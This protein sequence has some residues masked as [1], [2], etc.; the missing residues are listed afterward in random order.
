M[1][2]ATRPARRYAA[3][4]AD[5][6]QSAADRA[7]SNPASLG[8]G[9]DM[10]G[11]GGGQPASE[12]Y[13]LE[14]LTRAYS[15]AILEDGRAVLPYGP[16]GGLPALRQIVAER[17]GMRG[18]QIGPENVLILTGSIQGL[19]LV[20]RITLDHGD[21]I[22]TEAPTFMGALAA[23]EHQQPNYL[24][25]PVDEHGMVVEAL[26]DALRSG[27]ANRHPKFVYLMPTFQNPSG[28]SLT[29]HRRQRLLEI[30][31]E[32]DLLIVEDDPYGEFWFD[33]AMG[34]MPP[35]KSLPG[36]E[37]RVIYLGTFSKILAPG[38][39]L[40]YAVAAPA[41]IELLSRAK[42]GI[43][44]HSDTLLQQAVVHLIRDPE[45]DFEAHVVEGRQLYKARR[46]AMLDS[47]EG[48]FSTETRWTRPGGGFFLWIDLPHGVSG[49]AVTAAAQ[50][51]G[52]AVLQGS[53]FYPNLDGGFNGLRLSYS[54][55]NPA[56]IR[57]GIERLHRALTAVTG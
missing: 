34:A 57:E 33:D 14:A 40:A 32:H 52:V 5:G 36:A 2:H 11:F 4:L 28:V 10:I 49:D 1:A 16:S 38:V 30:A 37:E 44:F 21:T 55:A 48:V 23:W 7:V 29:L 15:R 47:L 18:V 13:P 3:W 22:V 31:Q 42:R 12:S 8:I 20:G 6:I 53:I 39:R 19:H 50:G 54:N 27:K 17:L 51:E 24:T 9:A 46:D 56:L 35:V 26:A 41:T 43:D 25:I 45:F